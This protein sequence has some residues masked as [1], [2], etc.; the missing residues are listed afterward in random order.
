MET[1]KIYTHAI[2]SLTT[3]EVKSPLDFEKIV[4][5]VYWKAY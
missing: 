3:K 4:I 1:T 2:E 5:A